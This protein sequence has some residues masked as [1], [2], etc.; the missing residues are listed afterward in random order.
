MFTSMLLEM[1][2]V[3][4]TKKGRREG[5]EMKGREKGRNKRMKRGKTER[6]KTKKICLL[7]MRLVL[8][9]VVLAIFLK[10]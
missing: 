8:F 3:I 1:F 4:N 5:G 7:I 2:I 6:I 9:V 10:I